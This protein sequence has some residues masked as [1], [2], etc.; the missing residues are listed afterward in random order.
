MQYARTRQETPEFPLQYARR[1]DIEGT[2]SQAV[3]GCGLRR[4]R[5]RGAAK[6]PIQ[7]VATAAAVNICRL[8]NWLNEVP[9]ANTRRSHF[10]ALAPAS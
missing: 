4:S 5:Y 3:W 1:A 9:L 2:L 7:H 6:T 10:A 8:T